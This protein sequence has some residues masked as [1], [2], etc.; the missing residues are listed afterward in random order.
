MQFQSLGVLLWFLPVA[1]FII[2]LYLLKVRRREIRVPARFLWPT[3]T[4]DVRANALFQ[5]LRPNLLLFLQLLIAFLLLAA[6][7]RPMIQARGLPGQSVIVVDASASMGAV[8]NGKSR[9]ERAR[10]RLRALVRELNPGEQVA[11]IEAGAQVR[12]AASLTAD[13]Q[14]LYSAIDSLQLTDTAGNID[15]ALRLA[16]ALVGKNQSG[17]IILLSDGAFPPVSDFSPGNA[18]LIY[19]SLGATRENVAITAMDVQPRAEGYE[20]F[21]AL[22]NF[23]ASEASGVLEFYSGGKLIDARQIKIAP[24]Q[25]LAQTLR[26]RQLAEPLEARLNIDDALASD[27]RAYRVGITEQ[28]RRVLI[29][30]EGNFFLERALA[31]EPNVEV[32]KAPSVPESERGQRVGDSQYDLIIFDNAPP[33]PVK[34]RAVM[35]VRA[36]GGPIA[37]LSGQVKTPRIAVWEKEHPLLRYVELAPVLIDNT[38]RLEPAP[39][40]KVIAESQ[41]TPLIVAGEHAGRR[42]VGIGWNLLES[43]FPLQPAF[44]IFIGN[45][46]RWATGEQGGTQGFTVR[47]GTPFS[48][49]VPPDETRL[50]LTGPDSQKQEF[51][52]NE[53]TLI[54]PGLPRVGL[55]TLQGNKVRIP[56]GGNLFNTDESDI[57][58][59]QTIQLGG[60][61]V[62]AQGQMFTLRDLWRPIV[63]LML[64]ILMLEWWVFVKRS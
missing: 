27:N 46:L 32:N 60:R 11:I 61:T 53:G 54:V 25:T 1:A 4:T 22:R 57:A 58:P 50:T 15:E 7:A 48:V 62:Q 45:L 34:A 20:W 64:A 39:W 17:R 35:V 55:Y 18:Q 10:E 3:I 37:K 56:V 38:P 51:P 42:W 43:D 33:V 31:L 24:G 36:Q 59:R 9:F 41:Q 21:V 30:G 19:E 16:S 2:F 28:T 6:L 13:K 63:L 5:K 47:T 8:E 14:R 23:G 44:P 49:N 29:V 40:A 12:V 26:A 52:V